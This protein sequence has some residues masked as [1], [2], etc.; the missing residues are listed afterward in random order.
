MENCLGCA[1][2]EQFVKK[3]LHHFFCMMRGEVAS[4]SG[5]VGYEW[6]FR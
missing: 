2:W 5:G 4:M 3:Q 1:L 6:S